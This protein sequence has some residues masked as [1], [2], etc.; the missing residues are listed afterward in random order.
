MNIF[1]FTVM[2]ILARSRIVPGWSAIRKF[3]M[4]MDLDERKI[5]ESLIEP[6]SCPE[7][8]EC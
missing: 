8:G 7:F 4:L 2:R 3:R 5:A 1:L 6:G